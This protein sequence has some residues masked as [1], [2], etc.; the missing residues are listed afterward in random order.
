[1]SGRD[2]RPVVIIQLF[3]GV[4]PKRKSRHNSEQV[5]PAVPYSKDCV[6]RFTISQLSQ[7]RLC[8]GKIGGWDGGGGWGFKLKESGA[9]PRG[10]H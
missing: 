7:A 6:V 10:S 9:D 4:H 2:V 3:V 1:V 5:V 8:L